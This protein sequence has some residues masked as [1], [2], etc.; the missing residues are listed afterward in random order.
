MATTTASRPPA[1][2]GGGDLKD[3][4][5]EQLAAGHA[6]G[7]ERGVVG[8][9]ADERPRHDLPDDQQRG[10]REGQ[11]EQGEGDRLRADRPLDGRF[12]HRLVGDEHLPA[13]RRVPR[14]E[15]PR[16]VTQRGQRGARLELHVDT[17]IRLVGGAEL[18]VE[19]EG[20]DDLRNLVLVVHWHDRSLGHEHTHHPFG[21]R[22]GVRRNGLVHRGHSQRGPHP[23][24]QLL[25]ADLGDRDL[26]RRVSGRE[27]AGE[28]LRD[29]ERAAE[30]AVK[31]GD[32]VGGVVGRAVGFERHRV[33]AD[34]RGRH[35]DTGQLADRGVE[36]AGTRPGRRD[37]RAGD[38]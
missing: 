9:G 10:K 5:G 18:A 4:G 3:A 11:G 28:Q 34:H 27:A 7:G 12:L 23:E 26:L 2:G 25:R 16:A 14:G 22:A 1:R 33:D 8:G 29:L 35:R 38:P 21:E 30:P 15:L 37:E 36:A 24:V 19:R 32:R 6:E 17:V 31:R 13:G 20:R